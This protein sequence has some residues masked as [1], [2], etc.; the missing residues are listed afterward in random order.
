M[1]VGDVIP[2]VVCEGE[3]TISLRAYHPKIVAASEGKLVIDYRWYLSN[4]VLP[5]VARLCAPME[6][7]SA[8]QI[9]DCLGMSYALLLCPVACCVSRSQCECLFDD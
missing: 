9:A 7:T 2:Y 4:Q 5:P 8:A 3:G 6:D 1:R